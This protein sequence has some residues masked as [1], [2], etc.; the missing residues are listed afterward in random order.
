MAEEML[1]RNLESAFDAG[2]DF[3]NRLLLSRTMAALDSQ[4]GTAGRGLQ[5]HLPR[6]R[7]WAGQPR[8]TMQ[9]IAVTI[10]VLLAAATAGAFLIARH[11]LTQTVPA[12]SKGTIEIGSD[13]PTSGADASWGLPTQYG[14]AFAVAQAGSVRGFTLKFVPNDDSVN[15]VHDATRGAQNVQ[16]MVGDGRVLGMVGPFHGSV[17]PAEIPIANQAS[18]AMISPANHDECLTIAFDYC[19]VL[20]GFTPASLRPA[21]PNNYFRI[22]AADSFQ[23]P[24]MADFAY[25][26]L[27][28]RKI[29][30]WDDMQQYGRIT[31]DTFT[32]EFA[33][34]GGAV[35]ARQGFDITAG[36]APDFHSWLRAARAAGAQAIY[37]G[38]LTF[39]CVA[40]AQSLG[41]FTTDSYY[42]GPDYI[43]GH[44]YGIASPECIADAGAMANDRMY[45]TEVV[46]DPNLNPGAAATIA[47]YL[48][49]HPDPGDTNEFTFAGYDAA[50]ILIDAIGRAIDANGGKMPTR[51]QVVGQL[52]QTTNYRGLTGTYTFNPSGDPTAPTLR[53]L[54][55]KGGA[56]IPIKNVTVPSSAG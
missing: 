1:R 55:V 30:V 46:G 31:A 5:L 49:L 27:G 48:T 51:Q 23:G 6:S 41:I 20:D 21:G 36:T 37:A 4:A 19:H 14:A 43:S 25:D 50:A 47:A 10:I 39:S 22:A 32:E 17:A 44:N 34:K 15:G 54:Q 16:L 9:L 12:S 11:A 35:V 56:W 13:L 45:A 3:P 52:A 33:R 7:F 2:P 40:R 28:L 29:A 18:L 26:T 24:A 8:R 42:L 53:I 38:A